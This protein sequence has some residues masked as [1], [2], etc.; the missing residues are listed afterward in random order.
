M[1]LFFLCQLVF[2]GSLCISEVC[3][4]PPDETAGEFVE[5]F[6]DSDGTADLAGFTITDG[7]ALDGIEGWSGSFPHSGVVLETT[8]IPPGGYAVLLEEGYVNDPWLVF[9]PGT[10]ILTTG[11]NAICNGLAASSDPLTLYNAIGTGTENVLSTFGTPLDAEEWQNRDDDGLDCIPLD[12][13]EGNTLSRYP[14]NSPDCEAAW[15]AGEPTPGGAPVAPP[16]TFFVTIDSLYLSNTDPLPGTGIFFGAIVS[17]H[18]TVSPDSGTVTLYIDINGDSTAQAGEHL[19][20]LPAENLQPGTS[21]TLEVFFTAPEQG[22][23]PA[24]CSAVHCEQ[25]IHFTTG[26]G[27]NPVITEVMANPLNEDTEEFIEIYYPGPGVFPLEGCSFTDGDAVDG[28]I[29]FGN[30]PYLLS[31]EAGLIIDPEYTG[32]LGIP[33]GTPLFTPLNSTLGNGLTTT[34][35][36]LLYR[37][38]GTSLEYLLSTAGTPFLSDDPLLCD[39]DGLDLIPF[40]PGNGCSMEK[41]M[42]LGPDAQFNWQPSLPGGTP[43][44]VPCYPGWTDL[45]TDALVFSGTL[46]GVF[47]N[48]GILEAEGEITFFND[49]SGN[50]LPETGEIIHRQYLTLA[51]GQT[52]SIEVFCTLPDSGLFTVAA[53]IEHPE[54]TLSANNTKHIQYIPEKPAWPVVTE[55]LANPSN[56][57]CDEFVELFFP[58]PGQA[59]ITLFTISDNDS[60]DILTP[61][62]SPFITAGSYALVM[63]PE[64]CTGGQPYGIPPGTPVFYPGNTTIGDGLSATDPVL[65]F[66]DSTAVSQYGTP[67]NQEDGIPFDPGT[68][69]SVERLAPWLPDAESSWF[70]SPFGPTPGGPPENITDGVDYAVSALTLKP[71][72]GPPGTEAQVSAEIVS[73]GTDSVL[74]GDLILSIRANGELIHTAA[75]AIPGLENTVTVSVSWVFQGNGIPVEAVVCC[76]QDQQNGNDEKHTV[77][78]PPPTLCIT[79]IFYQ[80]P[81]WVELF[82]GGEYPLDLCSL[83]FSDPSTTALMGGTV[84]EPGE[85]AVITKDPG[86][87][88][89][90]WGTIPCPVIQPYNWPTLNNGGDSLHLHTPGGTLDFVP[91]RSSWGGSS[92]ESLERRSLQSMGF[93]GEN[94][95]TCIAGGTPGMPNSIGET[96]GGR[97]LS[98]SPGV[99]N[100]PGTPLQIEI[101]LPMQAC[102]V[103]VKVYDVR[104]ME[105]ERLYHGIAPGETLVL[106]WWGNEYPVGRYI[107]YAEAKC[108]GEILT[109]AGVVVLARP[110][111]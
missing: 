50:L 47:S 41:M 91:Y 80:E 88:T 100:P 56:E 25:R 83:A 68:D 60:E 4:N 110:L 64:Y 51:P 98:L 97:F 6:N 42:P 95:G 30:G 73:M 3:S 94:W 75:P 76:S 34:D 65:L 32:T 20:S 23:Y 79:E 52:D 44:E 69:L 78:N 40:D 5:L 63:D 28:V 1:E 39:D 10:V 77:W 36:V 61:Q 81:E 99:F 58:G 82:N 71:P 106:Q 87:F 7:D 109:D 43:G 86:D 57:D 107:V 24:V 19:L 54:D 93:Q 67:E 45:A 49:T 85:Y 17:C 102:N 74:Q 13:G 84:I 16:D 38:G 26:G 35:P 37:P 92:S 90:V 70:S 9:H 14:L 72:M 55:V 89:A 53:T 27:V 12:P 21:D 31:G 33:P 104:G 8:E 105:L 2:T 48:C 15:F 101:N 66:F 111:R 96:S 108:A 11:D 46:K 62:T 22:W 103:T 29:R 18:G 59:D